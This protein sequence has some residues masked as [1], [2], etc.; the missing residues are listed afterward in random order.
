MTRAGVSAGRITR[1]RLTHVHGD[2]C[3]GLPGVHSRLALDRAEHPVHLHFP[4]G[5]E[6]TGTREVRQ[7]WSRSHAESPA[8]VTP[9]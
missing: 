7:R 2:H 3:Y 1:I 9:S 5:S 4:S 8:P 6:E